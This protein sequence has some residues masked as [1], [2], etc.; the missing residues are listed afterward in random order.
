MNASLPSEIY[1]QNNLVFDVADDTMTASINNL[2]LSHLD[3][4]EVVLGGEL[5]DKE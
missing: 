5:V 1:L 4:F 2:D 3:P